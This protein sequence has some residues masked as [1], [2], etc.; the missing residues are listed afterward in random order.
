MSPNFKKTLDNGNRIVQ[1]GLAT[2]D[3]SI[4]K[5]K[6]RGNSQGIGWMDKWW[7]PLNWCSFLVTK[8]HPGLTVSS[9]GII[10]RYLP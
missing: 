7:L 3:G 8:K 10:T 5:L 4:R 6:G 9:A 1:K 2:W